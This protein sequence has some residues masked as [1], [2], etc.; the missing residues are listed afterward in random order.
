[1]KLLTAVLLGAAGWALGALLARDQ[2]AQESR[3]LDFLQS[4]CEE[5][6]P[7]EASRQ[8][9]GSPPARVVPPRFVTGQPVARGPVN[10]AESKVRGDRLHVEASNRQ[11]EGFVAQ[12]DLDPLVEGQLRELRTWLNTE[13]I[14]V[15]DQ[16]LDRLQQG[17]QP[18]PDR[19]RKL[20]LLLVTTELKAEAA[21][22]FEAMV[23]RDKLAVARELQFD[24][25][26]Q[27]DTP[28]FDRLW[29][30]LGAP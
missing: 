30:V 8:N 15:V 9:Q 23:S 16:T 12:A 22:R 5:G 3:Q 29:T 4:V 19:L 2:L 21:R 7:D 14:R 20:E 28:A 24:I 18:V 6:R 27:L 17:P 10:P 26:N 13:T 1:M 11:L 25:T